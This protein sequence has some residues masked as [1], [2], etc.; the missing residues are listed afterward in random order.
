MQ[1]TKLLQLKK[2]SKHDV[3]IIWDVCWVLVR[4]RLLVV[5]ARSRLD[6]TD[7]DAGSQLRQDVISLSL[8]SRRSRNSS[9]PI[10]STTSKCVRVYRHCVERC[11]ATHRTRSVQRFSRKLHHASMRTKRATTCSCHPRSTKLDLSTCRCRA[12]YKASR[13]ISRLN[14]LCVAMIAS[15]YDSDETHRFLRSAA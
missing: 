5:L 9:L 2:A 13:P 11:S 10:T 14:C 8:S 7:A 6:R 15:R 1:A 4:P 3:D 12:K